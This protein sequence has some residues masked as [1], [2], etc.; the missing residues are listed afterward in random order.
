MVKT[1]TVVNAIDMVPAYKT[2]NIMWALDP[3]ALRVDF[4]S[5]KVTFYNNA[6]PNR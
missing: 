6:R 5:V 3:C 2:Y 1:C 4:F